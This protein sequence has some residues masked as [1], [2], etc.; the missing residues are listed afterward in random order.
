MRSC[1][2]GLW[3]KGVCYLNEVYM[4]HGWVSG[5]W[6]PIHLHGMPVSYRNS[7]ISWAKSKRAAHTP[8]Y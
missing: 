8:I 1:G 2:A 6:V 7:G 3:A 5:L 4:R